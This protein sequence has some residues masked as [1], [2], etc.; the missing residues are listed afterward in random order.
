MPLS[1]KLVVVGGEVKSA[2]IKLRLPSTIGRGRGATIMLP[3]P[4]VSRQHCELFETNGRLM[5]RDLGSLNGTFVNNERIS[6]APLPPGELLT[7]G[8]VTFRAVYEVAEASAPPEGPGPRLK[9]GRSRDT[10]PNGTARSAPQAA[11]ET[12]R[13]AQAS[14]PTVP[15]DDFDFELPVTPVDEAPRP[16]DR[17]PLPPIRPEATADPLPAGPAAP[18]VADASPGRQPPGNPAPSMPET[19]AS[20]QREIASLDPPSKKEK[21]DS[22]KWGQE[23]QEPQPTGQDDDDFGDFLKSLGPK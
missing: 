8:A 21:S 10:D 1:A 17:A 6:E 22:W 16:T 15:L 20:P 23:D 9:A 4:L 5:V 2:E 3:H 18:E 12:H 7:V 13:A 14:E 19:T 11:R